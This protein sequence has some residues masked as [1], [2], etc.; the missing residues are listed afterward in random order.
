MASTRELRRRIRSVKN[1]S[2]VTKA[3]QMV[4]ASKMR[5]AQERALATRPYSERAWHVLTNLASQREETEELHPL[6]RRPAQIRTIGMILITGDRGLCGGYNHN[7]IQA[8]IESMAE[9]KVPVKLITVGRKGREAMLRLGRD[10]VAEF[11]GLPDQPSVTDVIPLARLVVDGFRQGTF[12][13]VR[14]AYT[15]FI[16]TLVQKPVVRRLLPVLIGAVEEEAMYE[17]IPGYEPEAVAE[18]I[19]EPDPH[20]ILDTV[21]PRFIELRLYQ[22]VLESVASEHSARM[23]SMQNATNNALELIDE[24][25]L[26][27]N[28]ARQQDITSEMLDIA[29]GAEALR[30]ARERQA[31]ERSA[32]G[33]R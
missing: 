5:R 9:S 29:G 21:V 10:I 13:L 18:Y 16:N 28:R 1:I 3:M 24:L 8:A 25:T 14:L 19:Y 17:Y 2:Q 26:T 23:V 32:Q 4:A 20:T 31:Q 12:D 15:D 27:Y 6:L 33:Y 7:V 11:P 22:A 30:Q